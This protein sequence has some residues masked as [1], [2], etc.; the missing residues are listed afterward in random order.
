MNLHL[1]RHVAM[2]PVRRDAR[3]FSKTFLLTFKPL[4]ASL[5]GYPTD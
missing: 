2:P 4:R 3:V 1:L 5:C